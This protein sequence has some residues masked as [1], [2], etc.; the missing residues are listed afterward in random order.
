MAAMNDLVVLRLKRNRGWPWPDDSW[1]LSPMY[2]E[3]GW[4]HGCGIPKGPQVG[5]LVLRS[6][7][8]EASDGAWVPNWSFDSVCLGEDLTGVVEA[9]Y[10]SVSLLPVSWHVKAPG[11]ATQIA[12][13][14]SDVDWFDHAE[15]G[16][17]AEDCLLYTS[18]AADE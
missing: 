14:V 9:Q 12:P 5:S 18:D 6:R 15:L 17:H 2:G 11:R 1:G 8:F 16:A 7:G 13:M 3:D 10:P 4:C